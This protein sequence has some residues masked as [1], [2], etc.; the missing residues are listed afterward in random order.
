[1]IGTIERARGRWREI[2][3]QLG[4]APQFLTNRHTACPLCGGK[5]RYRFDD[6]DGE[7]TYF[8]NQCGPGPGI[9]LVRKLNG[10][11]H[12]TACDEI[13]RI[14]GHD[15]RPPA[16]SPRTDD[17]DRRR[18]AIERVMAGATDQ[19][20]VTAYLTGRGLGVISGV[21]RGHPALWHPEAKKSLPAVLAPIFGPSGE[22]QSVQR[23]FMGDVTPRKMTMPPVDTI[24][25]GAVRLFDAA[26][27]MGVGE[28]VVT[29]L[30]AHQLFRLPT[31]ATLSEGGLTSFEPPA[32]LKRLHIF[33]DH[34]ANFVGQAANYVLAKRMHRLGIAVEVHMPSDPDTDWADVLN[35][36]AGA[37]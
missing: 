31:W 33:G 8:C 24:T 34:D 37:E 18:Q 22:L 4:I 7:G 13:D 21:L 27:E 36:H 23:I 25:G 10:W 15:Y 2:L 35:E 3:P 19:D 14:I 1:M 29:S 5:D 9:M 32:G 30:A 16:P 11:D 6:R 17:R 12:K 20:V 28:G 26:E